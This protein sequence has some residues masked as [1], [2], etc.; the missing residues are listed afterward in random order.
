[1]LL[2]F[3]RDILPPS[4]GAKCAL[5]TVTED[6]GSKYLQNVD[7]TAHT[8]LQSRI[9]IYNKVPEAQNSVTIICKILTFT[10]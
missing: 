9:S 6:G 2:I 8:H 10:N 3:P 5:F 7:N 1:M 4:S